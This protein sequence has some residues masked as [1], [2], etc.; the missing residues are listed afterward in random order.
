MGAK[1]RK[2]IPLVFHS[3]KGVS[4]S[5][6]EEKQEKQCFTR[7]DLEDSI[8]KHGGNLSLIARDIKN[9]LSITVRPSCFV[10]EWLRLKARKSIDIREILQSLPG[11]T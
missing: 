9:S 7:T 2:S 8:R 5:S 3:R 6:H 11:N 1:R 10:I 4:L